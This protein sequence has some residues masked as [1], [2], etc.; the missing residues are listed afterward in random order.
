MDLQYL[1]EYEKVEF[2]ISQPMQ[3]QPAVQ[4]IC[5]TVYYVQVQVQVQVQNK[6]C[7]CKYI[8]ELKGNVSL[9]SSDPSIKDDNVRFKTVPLKPLTD[10]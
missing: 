6:G 3:D 8:P 4:Y 2:A 9:I 10:R 7:Y 1:E 5:S